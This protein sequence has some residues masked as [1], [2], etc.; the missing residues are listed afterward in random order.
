[1]IPTKDE[2]EEERFGK[3]L[4][5]ILDKIFTPVIKQLKRDIN[6]QHLEKQNDRC[7]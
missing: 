5:R 4:D 3:E 1:M 6:E 7:N 2:L